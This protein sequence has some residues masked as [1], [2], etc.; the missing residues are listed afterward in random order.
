MPTNLNILIIEDEL[1]IAEMLKEMLVELNYNVIAIAQNFDKASNALQTNANINFVFLDINLSES[2]SGFNIAELINNQYKIPF[3]FLTSYSDPETIQ[4]A[5]QFKPQSYL[6]KPFSKSDLLVTLELYKSRNEYFD[7]VLEIKDG[8]FNTKINYNDIIYVKS[9][10][11]YIEIKTETKLFVIRNSL[12]KFL[13]QVNSPSF[14]RVHRSYVV[15]IKYVKALNRLHLIVN[16]EK[17]PISRKYHEIL[18][19]K[20]A[21]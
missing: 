12:E 2:K 16:S 11:I 19:Q 15:N 10:N 7:G 17:I 8:H 5:I 18:I 9:E 21:V 14:V 4:K 3:I 20:F 1:L 6:I 13:E